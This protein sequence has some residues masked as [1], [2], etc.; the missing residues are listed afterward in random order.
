MM[1]AEHAEYAE[2]QKRKT[3][4]Q[5]NDKPRTAKYANH[6]TE[7]TEAEFLTQSSQGA[8]RMETQ[9]KQ[10][11]LNTRNLLKTERCQELALPRRGG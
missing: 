10:H 7:G 1:P 8:R 4:I 3:P 2:V 9:D 5:A 11:V 6:K